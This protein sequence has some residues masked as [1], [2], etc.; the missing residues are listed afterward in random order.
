ML[1]TCFQRHLIFGRNRR[2]WEPQIS[3]GSWKVLRDDLHSVGFC[4]FRGF[5]YDKNNLKYSQQYPLMSI[6]NL[7]CCIFSLHILTF[8]STHLTSILVY[9]RC[10]HWEMAIINPSDRLNLGSPLIKAAGG[11]AIEWHHLPVQHSHSW[12]PQLWW[13]ES[14]KDCYRHPDED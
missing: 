2:A 9:F 11:E 5:V 8:T 7:K 4:L 1:V 13:A 6:I 10:G 3:W 12:R 14:G